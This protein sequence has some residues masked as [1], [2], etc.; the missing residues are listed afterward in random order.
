MK[1][2]TS[3]ALKKT[4]RRVNE[5]HST[6]KRYYHSATVPMCI[7]REQ[8]TA[9]RELALVGW[10]FAELGLAFL[11]EINCRTLAREHPCACHE[12]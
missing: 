2:Y 1:P 7:F 10:L 3:E 6:N 8:S 5:A 12:V 11:P 9:V 4:K